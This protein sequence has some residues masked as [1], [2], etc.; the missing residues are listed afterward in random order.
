[1][2]DDSQPGV[3]SPCEGK[4]L[5]GPPARCQLLPFLFW[6]RVPLLK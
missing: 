3:D 4:I 6:G 2:G 1:M 5:L